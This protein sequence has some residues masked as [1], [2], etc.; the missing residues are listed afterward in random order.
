MKES[1][2]T[3]ILAIFFILSLLNMPLVN[4]F[5][6]QNLTYTYTNNEPVNHRIGFAIID[7]S[8]DLSVSFHPSPLEVRPGET[9]EF[10][11]SGS[12]DKSIENPYAYFQIRKNAIPV[13]E[14]NATFT[15]CDS[16]EQQPL[17]SGEV[18]IGRLLVVLGILFVVVLGAFFVLSMDAPR[19]PRRHEKKEVTKKGL[20]RTR[21]DVD[22][23]VESYEFKPHEEPKLS[24]VLI[25]LLVIFIVLVLGLLLMI[26]L[27]QNP[28]PLNA[29][30]ASSLP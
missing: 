23:L 6:E 25:V 1:K 17:L 27:T 16:G 20:E 29:L 18:P 19:K 24:T 14:F 11:L 10:T 3:Y 4:A 8:S 30:P 22:S 28:Q 13:G 21:I 5:C 7:R 12:S 26:I 15:L 2:V 9:R